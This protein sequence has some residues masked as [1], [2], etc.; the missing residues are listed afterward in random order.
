MFVDRVKVKVRGGN[1]GNGCASFRRERFVPRGGPDGGDGGDGGSVIFETHGGDL[2]LTPLKYLNHYEAASGQYGMGKKRHGKNGQDV[3]VKVPAGTLV[4]DLERNLEVV[5][6]L[7]QPGARFVAAQGGRGGR[8]NQHFA[9]S[10]NQAP[11]RADPGTQGEARAYELELKI[12]A[13]A[14]L[15]GYPNAGKSTLLEAVSNATPEIAPYPFSTLHPN[16]GLVEYA[17]LFRLTI[18]D[19]PGLI[20]GAHENVGLGHDFLRHIERTKL[21]IYVLDMAG[22]DGR[23]PWDDLANLQNELEMYQQG[24]S[25]RTAL[26]AANKMDEAAGEENLETL[27]THTSLP[28]CPVSALL[29]EG[30]D[31]LLEQ[32]RKQVEPLM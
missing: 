14:G 9:S 2:S 6:D 28:I 30:C 21:L 18:A 7:D 8:G 5:C 17:D 11:R 3:I 23:T 12:I 25:E 13:D 10:T 1:G 24:L 29:G 22:T 27:R 16:L 31:T 19:I 20:E 32:L 15:V 26:I 4:K